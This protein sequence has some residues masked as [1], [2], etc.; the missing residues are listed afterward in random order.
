M[1]QR[2]FSKVAPAL[3]HS[4]RFRGLSDQAKVYYLYLATNGHVSS[5][6]CYMLPDGYACADL[7][8]SPEALETSRRANIDVGLIDFDPETSEVLIERWF[9]HNPPANDDHA[10]GTRRR[11]QAIESDRLREKAVTAFEEANAA[12]IEREAQKAAEKAAKAAGRAQSV[13]QTIGSTARL[14]DTQIMRRANA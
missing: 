9:K 13:A 11:L 3:W 10:T 5:A 7:E 6:G 12:R 1:T 2:A 4:A 14:L 8:C